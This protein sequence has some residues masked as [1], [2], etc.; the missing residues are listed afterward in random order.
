MGLINCPE[1]QGKVSTA[2]TACPHCGYPI[3][4]NKTKD[5]DK[6][7]DIWKFIKLGAKCAGVAMVLCGVDGGIL[8]AVI[9]ALNHDDIA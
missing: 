8:T 6:G 5:S 7:N 4:S 1:C 3:N 9:D 2:A